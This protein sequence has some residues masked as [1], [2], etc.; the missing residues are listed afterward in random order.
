ME[1]EGGTK[2]DLEFQSYLDTQEFRLALNNQIQLSN[3]G[4]NP[5]HLGPSFQLQPEIKLP[6]L[7]L[8]WD[9]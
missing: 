2:W 1:Q 8:S 7:H 3:Q 9:Y 4:K 6:W 5:T